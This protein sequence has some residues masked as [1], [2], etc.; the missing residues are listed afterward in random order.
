MDLGPDIDELSFQLGMLNAFAEMVARDLKPLALG[1]PQ[2][3]SEL[4]EV[5]P[6]AERLADSHGV[7][8]YVEED[9]LETLLFDSSAVE[10][11]AVLI[12]Y[13][14]DGVLEEYLQLKELEER[15]QKGSAETTQVEIAE[16]FGRLLGYPEDELQKM[17]EAA[18]GG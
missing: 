1:A 4:E 3:P 9:L 15:R 11:K 10:D 14:D 13:R 8:S 12:L 18:V 7:S 17:L 2:D 5:L 6:L 16:R